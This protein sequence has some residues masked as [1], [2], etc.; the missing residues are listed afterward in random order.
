MLKAFY[1]ENLAPSQGER[2][3]YLLH[4]AAFFLMVGLMIYDVQVRPLLPN[5]YFYTFPV[6][7]SYVAEVLSRNRR[8]PLKISLKESQEC[9]SKAFVTGLLSIGISAILF[10]L[11]LFLMGIPALLVS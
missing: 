1:R 6:V 8:K 5:P 11:A 10:T 9:F 7:I 3:L 4:L 2:L